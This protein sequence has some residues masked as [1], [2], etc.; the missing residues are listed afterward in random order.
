MTPL[1]LLVPALV[2]ADE[3]A[4]GARALTALVGLF[5]AI[6]AYRGYRRND[7]P[8]MRSLAVGIFLLTTGVFSAVVAV[9]QLGAGTGIVLFIRGLVTAVGLGAILYALTLQ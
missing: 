4:W 3:V 1:E 8:K 2:S 7:V 6:L 5:V 9:S